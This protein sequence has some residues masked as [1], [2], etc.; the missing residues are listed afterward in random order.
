MH[1][2]YNNNTYIFLQWRS[3]VKYESWFRDKGGGNCA[4]QENGMGL[5]CAKAEY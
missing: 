1:N 3:Y 5:L 4:L 2:V